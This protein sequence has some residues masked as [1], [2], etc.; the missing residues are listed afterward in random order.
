MDDVSIL[1]VFIKNGLIS[2]VNDEISTASAEYILAQQLF[3]HC[4]FELNKSS[5][6]QHVITDTARK[7]FLG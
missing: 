4:I 2:T 3:L 6:L 7:Q 1:T 5:R